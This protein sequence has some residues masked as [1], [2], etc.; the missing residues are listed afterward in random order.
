MTFYPH[1]QSFDIAEDTQMDHILA[2][3]FG[4]AAYRMMV[5]HAYSR[6]NM[7]RRTY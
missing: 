6:I 5:A 3:Q 4:M 7:N 2:V 1:P